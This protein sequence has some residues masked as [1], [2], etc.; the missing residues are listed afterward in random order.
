MFTRV[1]HSVEPQFLNTH[2]RREAWYLST[3][4]VHPVYQGQ[5]LGRALVQEGLELVDRNQSASYLI[6]L[7]GSELF[8]PRFG[9]SEVCRVNVL[10]L[11]DWDGGSVMFRE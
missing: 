4:S 10:E 5:R 1:L 9:F 8:Y 3:L 11:K 7:K 6:S 2:R